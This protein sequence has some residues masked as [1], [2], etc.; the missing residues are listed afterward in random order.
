MIYT[1]TKEQPTH[2][3][4]SLP[5][6]AIS[7]GTNPSNFKS[8][9]FSVSHMATVIRYHDLP[10]H[11]LRSPRLIMQQADRWRQMLGQLPRRP[12]IIRPNWR[13][14]FYC[15][16]PVRRVSVVQTAR[17]FCF[18]LGRLFL[19]GMCYYVMRFQIFGGHFW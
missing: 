18:V 16:F 3:T 8:V 5:W 11:F 1:A 6:V 4:Q 12:G 15:A 10:E 2:M 19:P 9:R 7:S 13:D 17:W 14:F